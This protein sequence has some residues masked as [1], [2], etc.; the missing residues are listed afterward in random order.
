MKV[1]IISQTLTSK[2]DFDELI[3]TNDDLLR[4]AEAS[5]VF[6]LTYGDKA[7][8]HIS[9][10]DDKVRAIYA[11]AY[12]SAS[13]VHLAKTSIDALNRGWVHFSSKA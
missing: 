7:E 12:A 11:S 2:P 1:R 9:E 8:E 4:A 5:T 6:D 3:E 10:P 13:T